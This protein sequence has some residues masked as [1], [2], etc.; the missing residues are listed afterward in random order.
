MK[1]KFLD[2]NLIKAEWNIF[3]IISTITGFILAITGSRIYNSI[4]NNLY[5]NFLLL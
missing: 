2:V 5:F 4:Y 3:S 1:Q